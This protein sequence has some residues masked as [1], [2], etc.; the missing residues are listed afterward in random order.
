MLR[1]T[2]VQRSHFNGGDGEDS[3]TI[4]ENLDLIRSFGNGAQAVLQNHTAAFS[5]IEE[6]EANAVDDAIADYDL[7]TVDFRFNLNGKWYDTETLGN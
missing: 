2:N 5:D 1:I 3:V 6:L 4:V 7:E